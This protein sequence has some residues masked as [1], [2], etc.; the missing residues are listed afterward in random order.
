MLNRKCPPKYR[1]MQCFLFILVV[2]A[3]PRKSGSLVPSSITAGSSVAAGSRI[4]ARDRD[5][6]ARGRSSITARIP[7]SLALSLALGQANLHALRKVGRDILAKLR[8]VLPIN[9]LGESKR[10]VDDVRVQ[11]EEVLGDLRGTR[12]LVVERRNERGRVA[13][14]VDLVVDAALR[15]DGALE[16]GEGAGDFG[17]FTGC[18]EAVLEDVAEVNFA[19][20]HGEELGGAGVDV[21]CVDAAGVEEA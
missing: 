17:V 15:E 9:G 13:L 7:R 6:V 11:A 19:V 18:D 2:K 14:V 1:A 20:D 5:R 16:L 21:G 4:P 12:V 10:S 8:D 3:L